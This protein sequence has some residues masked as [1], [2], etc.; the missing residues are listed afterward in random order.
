MSA[1]AIEEMRNDETLWQKY[2]NDFTYHYLHLLA[3]SDRLEHKLLQITFF[4]VFNTY[5]DMKAIAAHCYMYLYQLDLA[6]VVAKLKPLGKLSALKEGQESLYPRNPE[7]SFIATIQ[8]TKAT[9]FIN[10]SKYVIESLFAVLVNAIYSE[11]DERLSSL[12]KWFNSYRDMVSS[13]N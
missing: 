7:T 10:I 8:K 5:S 6:K 13:C 2:Y 12:L 1:I 11:D 9:K 3:D 4:D